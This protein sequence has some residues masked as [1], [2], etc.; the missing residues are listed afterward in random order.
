MHCNRPV[1]ALALAHKISNYFYE[2]G[3]GARRALFKICAP[4]NPKATRC[5]LILM[6]HVLL[7]YTRSDHLHILS[8][9]STPLLL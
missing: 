2:V 7:R 4:V 9:H 6:L 1:G 3:S 5:E 8:H